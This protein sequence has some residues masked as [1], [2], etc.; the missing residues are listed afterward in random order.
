MKS[1]DRTDMA[2]ALNHKN[3]TPSKVKI[4]GK[5]WSIVAQKKTNRL[6]EFFNLKLLFSDKSSWKERVW[7]GKNIIKFDS[8]GNDFIKFKSELSSQKGQ[9]LSELATKALLKQHSKKQELS[10]EELDLLASEVESLELQQ[11]DQ[12]FKAS[13]ARSPS[14]DPVLVEKINSLPSQSIE[15]LRQIIDN[16][17]DDLIDLAAEEGMKENEFYI[18]QRDQDGTKIYLKAKGTD[19]M[20]RCLIGGKRVDLSYSDVKTLIEKHQMQSIEDWDK[21]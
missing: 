21:F 17:E 18:A 8:T 20:D 19:W 12:F 6:K 7:N 2:I 15:T 3:Y 9:Q 14:L 16:L 13:L 4:N 1:V 11:S 5:T 10:P